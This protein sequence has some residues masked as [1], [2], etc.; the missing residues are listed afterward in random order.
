MTVTDLKQPR[1]LA[2]ALIHQFLRDNN[3][4]STLENLKIEADE[5]FGQGGDDLIPDKSLLAILEER[6]NGDKKPVAVNKRERCARFV[7]V[8]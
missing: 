5:F 1:D 3:Y 2:L 6:L 8:M 4:T 7:G